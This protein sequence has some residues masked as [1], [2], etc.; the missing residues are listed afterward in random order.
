MQQSIGIFTMNSDEIYMRLALDEARKAAE[1]GEVPVGA[2]IVDGGTVIVRACNRNR[3]L[4]DPVQHAEIIAIREAALLRAN[5]RLTGCDIYVTKEPCAMCAGAIVHAR[6]QRVYIGTEDEK[7]G[8]CG[9]VL[10]VCGNPRLNHI[11]EVRFGIL[12]EECAR[13]LTDFFKKLRR[14]KE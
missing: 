3:S 2:V 8:A 14:G 5:E 6:I 4:N 12:R 11:P 1:R 13:L 10:S 7:Y 9:T